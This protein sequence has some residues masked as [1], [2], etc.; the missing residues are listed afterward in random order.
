MLSV[1]AIH[2][3]RRILR[4]FREVHHDMWP[5][6][7]SVNLELVVADEAHR[8]LVLGCHLKV[9]VLVECEAI[10]V[11]SNIDNLKELRIWGGI[12]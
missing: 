7:H 9:R 2:L 6:A 8:N 1:T 11:P 12:V 4:E 5:H 10:L 3:Y